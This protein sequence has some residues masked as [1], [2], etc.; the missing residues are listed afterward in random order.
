MHGDYSL[1]SGKPSSGKQAE[2]VIRV[3]L[4]E[5]EGTDAHFVQQMLNGGRHHFSIT[6]YNRLRPAI[7]S[8]LASPEEVDV[9]LLGVNL[10]QGRG[11]ERFREI[12][13][14][15]SKLPI[16]V[17]C[18]SWDDRLAAE[19]VRS[20]AQDF[21]VRGGIET[22]LIERSILSA[23]ER[24]AAQEAL[25]VSEERYALAVEGTN[26][27]LWE[28]DVRTQHVYMSSR[29]R[30]I[31]GVP[32][33]AAMCGLGRWF[34]HVHR[35][36]L[37]VVKSAFRDHLSGQTPRLQVEHRTS[38]KRFGTRW[39]LVRG[40]CVRGPA[41]KA[42]RIGGSLTDVT[43]RKRT[44]RELIHNAFHDP[45]TS[46]PNRALF[47]DRVGQTMMQLERRGPANRSGVFFLD[48]DCFKQVN[49]NFGHSVGDRLL[50]ACARRLESLVRSADTVSR[51]GGDEFVMLVNDTKAPDV[52]HVAERVLGRLAEP[53]DIGAHRITTS[54]CLG[55]VL[56]ST[57][58]R[59]PEELLRD[60]DTAMYRAKAKGKGRYEIFDRTARPEVIVNDSLQARPE[61]RE[62]DLYFNPVVDLRTECPNIFEVVVG[63]N[64]P[65]SGTFEPGDFLDST[66]DTG[67]ML[68]TIS[69][70][71]AQAC[72]EASAWQKICPGV[73]I[74]VKISLR[75]LHEADVV[76][77]VRGTLDRAQLHPSLLILQLPESA[78][79]D[80][81]IE[82]RQKLARLNSAGIR[83]LI[84]NLASGRSSLAHLQQFPCDLVKIDRSFV[85]ALGR[86]PS[87]CDPSSEEIIRAIVALGRSE[88]MQ[89]IA[90]GIETEEQLKILRRIGCDLG[91]G[92]WFSPLL[93]SSAACAMLRQSAGG[94]ASRVPEGEM[95]PPV[96][97]KA[98]QEG[99]SPVPGMA[100]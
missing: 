88:G 90:D 71:L 28:W 8:A 16:I 64:Q 2:R 15:C 6:R 46:L 56:T 54:A 93:E 91:Q 58:Y 14:H 47:L 79:T 21:L 36:D 89:V 80:D 100:E 31:L 22:Q 68:P 81:T 63:R 38:D 42:Y 39:V 49:D 76:E 3:M 12:H 45:L 55:V 97:Q 4:I 85:D 78:F 96:W 83:L 61:G 11:L 18:D 27:G 9:V 7:E 65:G 95:R 98:A 67:L 94:G 86:D 33:E 29:C 30:Q 13:Q 25:R 87:G 48:L 70:V 52:R 51:L 32:L 20:G 23:I 1:A 59:N 82:L 73:A 72:T 41:G 10:R 74:S 43:E 99:D 53:F 19:V 26:D 57:Q 17:L 35:D 75:Q 44:E 84:A 69:W 40:V 34:A 50:I 66:D 62:L 77:S 24:E 92:L 5:D 60:A 37:A